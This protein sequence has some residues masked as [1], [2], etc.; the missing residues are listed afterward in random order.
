MLVVFSAAQR[1]LGGERRLRENGHVEQPIASSSGPR[2]YQKLPLP[3]GT[4]H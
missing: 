3:L 1:A 4:S 2:A